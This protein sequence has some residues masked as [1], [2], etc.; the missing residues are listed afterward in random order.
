MKK[1][2]IE[3]PYTEMIRD[4]ILATISTPIQISLSPSAINSEF[5]A[6]YDFRSKE[7]IETIKNIEF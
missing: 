7:V 4:K 1:P 5:Q 3:L 6:G 2:K